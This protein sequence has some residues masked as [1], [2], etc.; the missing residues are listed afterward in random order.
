MDIYVIKL[1]YDLYHLVPSLINRTPIVFDATGTSIKYVNVPTFICIT[2]AATM[3]KLKIIIHA[4]DT[5]VE[6]GNVNTSAPDGLQ[7]H[8]V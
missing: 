7:T 4:P 8:V 6:S 5:V 3:L 2:F 1:I